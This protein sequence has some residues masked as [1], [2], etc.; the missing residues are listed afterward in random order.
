MGAYEFYG[1]NLEAK[2][3]TFCRPA[4]TLVENGVLDNGPFTCGG[5]ESVELRPGMKIGKRFDTKVQSGKVECQLFSQ[6]GVLIYKVNGKEETLILDPAKTPLTLEF[7]SSNNFEIEIVSV[8][9]NTFAAFDR[10]RNYGR[11]TLNGAPLAGEWVMR[12]SF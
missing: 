9:E 4:G 6:G 2:I 12:F 5:W 3:M 8:P 11:S 1:D 10:R 7:V